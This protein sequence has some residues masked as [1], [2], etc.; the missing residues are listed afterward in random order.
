MSNQINANLLRNFIL[1][2]IGHDKKLTNDELKDFDIEEDVVLEADVDE[3]GD[4]DIDEILDNKT[5]Y[6][7]FAV[8]YN[9]E[10]DFENDKGAKDEDENTKRVKKKGDVKN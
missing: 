1:D 7:Q 9:N 5:L 2:K 3:S 6:E 4:L 10:N 8:M